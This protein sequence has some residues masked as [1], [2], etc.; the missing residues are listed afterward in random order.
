MF[1]EG[2]ATKSRLG[3]YDSFGAGHMHPALTPCPSHVCGVLVS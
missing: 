2:C 3:L 1:V